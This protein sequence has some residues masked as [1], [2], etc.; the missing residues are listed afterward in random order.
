MAVG[1]AKKVF[2]DDVLSAGISYM[3]KTL[4]IRCPE[5]KPEDFLVEHANFFY[6]EEQPHGMLN[7]RLLWKIRYFKSNEL[8]DK[9]KIVSTSSN[10]VDTYEYAA[11]VNCIFNSLLMD[12]HVRITPTNIYRLEVF[13]K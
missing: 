6:P 8:R 7:G 1:P 12:Q 3:E 2:S 10:P 5:P 4:S 9:W 13:L 11:V